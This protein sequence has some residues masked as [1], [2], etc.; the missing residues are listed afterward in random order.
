MK[1]EKCETCNGTG[2]V[3]DPS[4]AVWAEMECPDCDG[5]GGWWIDERN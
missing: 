1:W 2:N 4:Q 3:K 5:K